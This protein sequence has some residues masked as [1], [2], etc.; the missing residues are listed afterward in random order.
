MVHLTHRF[1]PGSSLRVLMAVLPLL[2][3]CSS[4]SVSESPVSDT[5]L[6]AAEIIDV[7]WAKDVP[8]EVPLEFNRQD[9]GDGVWDGLEPACIPG[10]GHVGCLCKS[11]DDCSSGH[12]TLHL[13]EKVC[14]DTCV[15]ECPGQ[16]TCK[17]SGTG[18]T[19]KVF[20]CQS[21]FPSVCLPCLKHE[22]CEGTGSLCMRSLRGAV[23]LTL[24][25]VGRKVHDGP[26][27]SGKDR[28]AEC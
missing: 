5:T 15:E 28:Q 21:V 14:T 8:H 24:C 4:G 13:G 25:C 7:Q 6:D 20:V 23:I 27:R 3:S 11:G 12:C 22:D 16:F 17:D 2:S 9:Q 19:D 10:H 26:Q 18:G 1:V